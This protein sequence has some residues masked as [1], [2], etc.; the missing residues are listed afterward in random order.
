VTVVRHWWRAPVVA[1]LV[2]GA[3]VLALESRALATARAAN[4]HDAVRS[5]LVVSATATRATTAIIPAREQAFLGLGGVQALRSAIDSLAARRAAKG[6]KAAERA[7]QAAERTLDGLLRTDAPAAT[8]SQ[9]ANLLGVLVVRDSLLAGSSS[10][11]ARATRLFRRAIELDPGNAG[12]K[13]NLEL[14]LS[15]PGSKGKSKS[16]K[17]TGGGT[18]AGSDAAGSGY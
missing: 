3:V 10:G 5:M 13:Y 17:K 2:V 16:A 12:A 4:D 8:R 15:L 6:R 1:A 14:L 18:G 11:I 7:Q 9:A